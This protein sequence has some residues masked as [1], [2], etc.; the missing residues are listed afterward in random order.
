MIRRI[1]PPLVAVAL[2]LAACAGDSARRLVREEDDDKT[3]CP[4]KAILKQ[5]GSRLTRGTVLPSMSRWRNNY[6]K[7]SWVT[8]WK[9]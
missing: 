2:I 7:V 9:P 5:Y 4:N 1:A 6:S 8:R 3:D